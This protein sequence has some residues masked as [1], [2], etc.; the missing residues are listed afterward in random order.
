MD[1]PS[2]SLF[3]AVLWLSTVL[4]L[5]FRTVMSIYGR[6]D[7][8]RWSEA[9]APPAEAFGRYERFGARGTRI[10]QELT[11]LAACAT[12]ASSLTGNSAQA[13]PGS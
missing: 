11:K 8:S 6:Q 13:R 4:I 10:G 7:L 12:A 2:G 3:L 1:Y 5:V 9:N